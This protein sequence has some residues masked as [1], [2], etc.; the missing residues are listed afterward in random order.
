MSHSTFKI[1]TTEE[2][3]ALKEISQKVF[4]FNTSKSTFNSSS[5]QVQKELM[6]IALPNTD[7]IEDLAAL[8]IKFMDDSRIDMQI[9]SYGPGSPQ[10]I[11]DKILALDLCNQANNELAR[12]IKIYPTRFSGLAVL[13]MADPIAASE[14]LERSVNLGLKGAM[15]SGTYNGRFFDHPEFLP[16]FYKAQDLNIPLYMHPAPIS[17]NIASSYY[18][19][20]QWPAIAGAMFAGAG[21]GWHLDSGIGIIRLIISGIFDKLPALKLISGHWGEMV[22][23]YLNRLDDQLGKTLKLDRKISEY[24][25]SNIYITPSGLFSEAQLQFAI[26]Q[27]GSDQILY[28][29]DYPFLIDKNT[30]SFLENASISNEDK[31]KIGYKNAESLFHL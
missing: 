23:F 30:R 25:K 14:E 26:S 1:I 8:R 18:Q 24:Y 2:H 12:L 13:P 3:F 10:N 5:N 20:D 17:E 15:L 7:V 11:T 29:G 21:Y 4:G 22:P 19:S 28:S 27:V 9:L 6:S 16:V 31:E